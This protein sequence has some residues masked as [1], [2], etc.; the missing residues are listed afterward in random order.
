MMNITWKK[1]GAIL[2]LACTFAGTSTAFAQSWGY[3]SQNDGQQDR[4]QSNERADNGRTDQSRRESKLSPDER[5]A[6]RRQIDEAGRDIYAPR[7]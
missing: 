3:R 7:R 5:R 1:S 6:L 4:R 2:L